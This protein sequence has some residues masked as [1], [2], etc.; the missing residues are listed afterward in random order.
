MRLIEVHSALARV[1]R[2]LRTS[3]LM[4]DTA[5]LHTKKTNVNPMTTSRMLFA[6]MDGYPSA[7]QQ[8]ISSRSR[9]EVY[10]D[11]IGR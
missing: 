7:L 8:E 10:V 5:K 1:L 3:S 4:P 6:N 9:L 11:I 2:I